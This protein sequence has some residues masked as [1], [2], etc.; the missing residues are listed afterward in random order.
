VLRLKNN[1]VTKDPYWYQFKNGSK[2]KIQ[3][4]KSN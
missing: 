2:I 3:A 1:M 4:M